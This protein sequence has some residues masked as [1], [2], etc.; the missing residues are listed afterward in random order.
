MLEDISNKYIDDSRDRLK[1]EFFQGNKNNPAAASRNAS[2]NRL[3]CIETPTILLRYQLLLPRRV[4][5][6]P[7]PR[8][9][10]LQIITSSTVCAPWQMQAG[11][12]YVRYVKSG[13][14]CPSPR[15]TRT[16]RTARSKKVY[17]MVSCQHFVSTISSELGRGI[18]NYI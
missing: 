13:C 12:F 2:W 8:C 15:R 9:R 7:A 4:H 1:S 3:A 17:I 14:C 18:P 6:S 11:D 10:E 16:D 5:Y